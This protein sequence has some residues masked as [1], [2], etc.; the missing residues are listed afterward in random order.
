MQISDLFYL[1]GKKILILDVNDGLSDASRKQL[2]L[3]GASIIG[4]LKRADDVLLAIPPHK[5]DAAIIEVTAD[6]RDLVLIARRLE[7]LRIPFV[8]AAIST[9]S[10]DF[11]QDGFNL[12]G[13]RDEFRK[14]T[15]A[16]FMDP[17][18]DFR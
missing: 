1:L 14:I 10:K 12:N 16:L 8:F 18:G 4:P 2:A 9:D 13:K 3:S 7:N 15:R 17:P 5:P 11:I 6:D